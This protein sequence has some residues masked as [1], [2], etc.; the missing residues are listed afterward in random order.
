MCN[1][2]SGAYEEA[3]FYCENCSKEHRD[4]DHFLH[5]VVNSPRMGV[6]GY[7]GELDVFGFDPKFLK[8]R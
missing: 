3:L 7:D 6:C 2:Y 5:P 1:D 4:D 8:V